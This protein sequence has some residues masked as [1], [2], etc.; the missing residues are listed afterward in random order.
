MLG[1]ALF[2][3]KRFVLP[4]LAPNMFFYFISPPNAAK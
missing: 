3:T 4:I 1:A 2:R